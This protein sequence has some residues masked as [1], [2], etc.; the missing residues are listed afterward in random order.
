MDHRSS[1]DHLGGL[2][3]DVLGAEVV[4]TRVGPP[5]STGTSN[6]ID[7]GNLGLYEGVLGC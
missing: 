2:E 7:P 1:L 5:N 4:D 6:L 3:P